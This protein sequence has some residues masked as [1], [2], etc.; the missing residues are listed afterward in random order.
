[1][2]GLKTQYASFS[3][4]IIGGGLAGLTAAIHLS[5][6]GV[7]VLLIEKNKFPKHKVCGEYISNEVLPYLTFLNID[8]FAL[9]AHK[10]DM[11]QLSTSKNKQI[12]AALPLGGFGIS[13][14][15]LD[16]ALAKKATNSGVELIKDTVTNITFT[17]NTFVVETKKATY[18]ALFVIGAH[19]KRSNLDVKLNRPFMNRKSPFLAVKTHLEG[20]FP[21]GL[22]ALH[23]FNGGYCGIS[24]IENDLINLCYITQFKT[25]KAYKDVNSFQEAI[26]FKNNHIKTVLESGKSVFKAPLTISQISFS[27]KNPIENHIIMCGDS[28]GLIHPLCGNGMSMAIRSAQMAATLLLAYFNGQITSRASLEQAYKMAW[29]K[30]FKSRLQAGHITA[31]ILN[32]STLANTLMPLAQQ[33]PGLLPKIITKTHG[34][35]MVV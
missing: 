33:I 8:V 29:N 9:G 21:D 4:I 16:H 23:N 32:N 14:F 1:M 10:I 25:F 31:S 26:L 22:V 13:R 12:K 27:N 6:A 15:T 34:K 19:G 18:K 7:K 2:R 30:E 20:H 35:P 3:V 28:A 5:N 17:N 24:K 11:L